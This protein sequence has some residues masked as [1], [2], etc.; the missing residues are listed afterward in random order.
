MVGVVDVNKY[1]SLQLN[2]CVF[3]VKLHDLGPDVKEEYG[4]GREEGEN[5]Y[6]KLSS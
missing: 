6:L 3:L 2:S 5:F 4:V 1:F